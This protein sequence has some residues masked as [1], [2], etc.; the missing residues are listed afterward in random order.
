M[1]VFWLTSILTYQIYPILI[2]KT[3]MKFEG[4]FII[5]VGLSILSIIYLQNNMKETKGLNKE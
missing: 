2:F 1:F 5:F 4:S 3:E